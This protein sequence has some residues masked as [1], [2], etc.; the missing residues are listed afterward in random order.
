MGCVSVFIAVAAAIAVSNKNYGLA[1]FL[2][3]IFLGIF[4]T[5]RTRNA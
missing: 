3:L 1:T 5:R 2:V 4:L